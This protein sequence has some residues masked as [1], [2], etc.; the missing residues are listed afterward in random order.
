MLWEIE[1]LPHK[2]DPETRR[3]N[4]EVALLTHSPDAHPVALASRGFLVEGELSEENAERLAS[5]L[6]V[7]ALVETGRVGRLNEFTTANDLSAFA[8]VMLR[9]GVMDPV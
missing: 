8:T 4:Q 7:D 9:S 1:I 2:T 6:L 3:V 5:D